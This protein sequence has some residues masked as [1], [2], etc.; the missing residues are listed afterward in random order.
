MSTS[1]TGQGTSWYQ[2]LLGGETV[3]LLVLTNQIHE[4]HTQCLCNAS[5]HVEA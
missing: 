3:T 2:V 1:P 5:H 4:R